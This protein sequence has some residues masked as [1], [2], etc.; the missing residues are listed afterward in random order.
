MKEGQ[1]MEVFGIMGNMEYFI[2]VRDDAGMEKLVGSSPSLDIARKSALWMSEAKIPG[3]NVV[4]ALLCGQEGLDGELQDF[5][6][7]HR[8]NPEPEILNATPQD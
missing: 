1:L 7:Y 3:H 4:A 6:I 2:F 8:G 5:E